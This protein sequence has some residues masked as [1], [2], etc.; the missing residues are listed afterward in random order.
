MKGV[1]KMPD[2]FDF[3]YCGA[4]H[5]YQ[6]LNDLFFHAVKRGNKYYVNCYGIELPYDSWIV[7]GFI[8]HKIWNM[9]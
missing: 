6:I 9:I 1:L 7:E 2:E 8:K 3:I 4:V 5:H